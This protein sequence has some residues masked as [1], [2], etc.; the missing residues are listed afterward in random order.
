MIAGGES[1]S[2]ECLPMPESVSKVLYGPLAV[3]YV[4]ETLS[5]CRD[6]TSSS[7]SLITE[8]ITKVSRTLSIMNHN[9]IVSD[10]FPHRQ[11][12]LPRD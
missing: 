12:L 1:P 10:L 4:S 5:A 6:I 7:L 9:N 8:M 11:C 3:T 2:R